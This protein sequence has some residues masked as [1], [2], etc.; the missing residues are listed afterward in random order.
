MK[1]NE[2]YT[3]SQ[4]Q[5]LKCL[6]LDKLSDIRG[7]L[8]DLDP[9]LVQLREADIKDSLLS[10]QELLHNISVSEEYNPKFKSDMVPRLWS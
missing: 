9:N 5:D 8:E 6:F 4:A 1:N 10:M 2:K 7:S 3:M